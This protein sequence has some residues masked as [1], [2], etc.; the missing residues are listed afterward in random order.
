M[1]AYLEEADK[2]KLQVVYRN[3]QTPFMKYILKFTKVLYIYPL[4]RRI[5]IQRINLNFKWYICQD[6]TPYTGV[7][8][9]NIWIVPA[10]SHLWIVASNLQNVLYVYPYLQP[11]LHD[12]DKSKFR[13]VFHISRNNFE[14]FRNIWIVP[15]IPNLC[16]SRQILEFFVNLSTFAGVFG[17]SGLINISGCI[18]YVT[19]HCKSPFLIYANKS[20]IF[21]L[22]I[23][24]DLQA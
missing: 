4:C 5:W 24:A 17:R 2:Y 13:L 6:T 12:V 11:Y 1:L 22:Q 23:N 20:S 9:H 18:S 14:D 16:L 21:L 3:P 15:A 7:V 19:K 8:Y 10:N